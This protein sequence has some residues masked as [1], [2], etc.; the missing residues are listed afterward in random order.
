MSKIRSLLL[1]LKNKS[2]D[3]VLEGENLDILFDSE[4]IDLVSFNL[5]KENKQEI[6]DFLKDRNKDVNLNFSIPK[7]NLR[8]NYPLS[9]SQKNLWI[10]SQ[11]DDANGAYNISNFYEFDG[12]L[13][14]V[15]IES[16]FRFLIERH[17]SLRTVFKEDEN[18]IVRQYILEY[19]D[20]NFKLKFDDIRRVGDAYIKVAVLEEEKKV[21]H[22]ADGPLI[23]VRLLQIDD[24]KFVI[25][26]VMHHIISDGWS[27]E[28]MIKELF[29]HYESSLKNELHT[30][31]SLDI[32]YKDYAVWQQKELKGEKVKPHKE[33]WKKQF[34]GE[35][36][37]L[38]LPAQFKR[39]ALKTYNGK[40][41]RRGI[42]ENNVTKLKE[43][44]QSNGS[45]LFM[46]L[47]SAVEVL[48]YKYTKQENIVIGTATAGRLHPDLEVQI[49]LFVNTL[50]LRVNFKKENSFLE[51][52]RIVKEVTIGAYE[53]QIFPLDELVL[54]LSLKRDISRNALFDVMVDLSTAF[55]TNKENGDTDL[56]D[57]FT[58]RPYADVEN[59]KSRFDMYF[60]F[61]ETPRGLFLDFT[62]NTDI[63]SHNFA[64]GLLDHFE[65][66]LEKI[67]T[68]PDLQISELD[69][70]NKSEKQ[71]LLFEFNN[72]KVQYSED[73]TVVDL[74]E[75]LVKESPDKTAVIF[76]QLELT[77]QNLNEK[78]NQ[79]A[80]YLREKYLIQP[81]DLIGIK[82][83]RS[84]QVL[85]AILGILKAGGGYVPIDPGYPQSRI[86]YIIKDSQCKVVLDEEEMFSF[87]IERFRYKKEN[88]GAIKS[89]SLAYV[90]YTSGTTGNPKGVMVEHRSLLNSSLSR[91]DFYK[92]QRTLLVSSFAFDSSVA[93]IWGGL[94][95]GGTLVIENEEVIKNAEKV[96]KS[97]IANKVTHIL[98]VPSYYTFLFDE[99][100]KH[101]ES[102]NLK[103]LI[104]AGEEVHEDVIAFHNEY[105]DNIELYNEYGPT[106]CTVWSTISIIK[107]S[108]NKTSIGS[109]IPNVQIYIL[110]EE[111]N[112]VPVGIIGKIFIS[113]ANVAR[114]Y[115]NKPE[116]TGEKFIVNPFVEGERMYDSGDL[117]C[118]MPDG[119][120]VFL[121]R[122]DNQVKIR[123]HRIELGEIEN[124]ILQ[125]SDS[126]K[127]VIV[128]LKENNG[129][130]VLA[131]Y[132]ESSEQIDKS[133]LRSFLLDKLPYYMIPG[134]YVIMQNIPLTLHGKIDRKALPSITGEDINIKEYCPA[135]NLIEEDL[136]AI[137]KEVLGVEKLGI[138]DNFFELGGHSL[139]VAQAINRI[140]K[141]INK[142]ISFKDFFAN[143]TISGL[144]L[145]LE[146]NKYTEIPIAAT[147]A[148]YPLT[149][150]QSRLWVLSQLE[151]GSLAYNMPAAIKLTGAVDT[152]RLKEAFKLL[153]NRHEILRTY[154]KVS[155]DGEVLQYIIP[156]EKVIFN[157]VEK[158][159]NLVENNEEIIASYLKAENE[160]L[161]DLEQGPLLR[162]SLIKLKK[163]EFLFF[164]SM[165]H[166]I[167]DG[168]SIE[169]LVSEIIK[170]YN[171]LAQGKQVDLKEFRIQYKDYAVWL[172][173]ES[174]QQKYRASEDYWLQQFKGELPVLSLPTFKTRPLIKTYNGENATHQ[175]S[176]VFLQKLQLFSREQ[177]VTL[178]M[179]LMAG[180]NALLCRYTGQED[181]IIGTPIAGREHPDLENQ[182]GLYL[183]T[184]A[185]RTQFDAKSN[186]LDLLAKQK[187]TLLNAYEHQ[188][189]PFDALVGK[190]NFKRDVSRSALFDALVVLQSQGQLKNQSVE[191]LN[192]IEVV[193]FNFSGKT[194]QFDISFTFIETESLTLVIE[195]NTDI[196]DDY[197]I[198]RIF[199]HFENLLTKLI[200]EP[201]ILIAEAGYLTDSE[202]QQLLTEF[203]N[204]DVVYASDKTIVDLFEEQVAKTPDDLAIV[205]EDVELTYKE[206]NEKANQLANYLTDRYSIE[207]DDLIGIKLDISEKMIIAVLGILKSGAAYVPID[208]NY[209][210]E[211]ILYM[212]RDSKCK[213]I[214]D[215]EQMMLFESEMLKYN[216]EN[217]NTLIKGDSLAYVIYTS[218]TTGNPKGVMVENQNLYNSSICRGNYYKNERVL[219][220]SSIAFDSSVGV[221][222]GAFLCG[223]TLIIIGDDVVKNPI[224]IADKIL[225]LG[226]TDMVCVPS[227]Y[228][229]LSKEL[230][231]HKK[232]LK[233]KS[234]LLAGEQLNTD[235]LLFHNK[236]F[237]AVT[238]YNE[239]GPTEATVWATVSKINADDKIIV[240]GKP[241]SN[242]QMYILDD[243]LQPVAV[244]G[245]GKIYIS[246]AGLARGY[247]N[248]PELTAEKFVSNPF[249]SNKRMY[250]TGD[251]GRWLPD[252]SIEFLGRKDDQVKLRGYRI[253]LSEIE[254]IISQYS[255]FIKHT[256]AEIQEV[257]GE[258]IIVG[259]YVSTSAIN[260][261]DLR[262]Y[263]KTK[264]PAFMIPSFFIELNSIPVTPNGKVDKNALPSISGADIIRKEYTAPRSEIEK[265][266]T[267]IWQEVLGV[268]N[269]GTTDDFFE[270]GGHSIKIIKIISKIKKQLK[271]DIPVSLFFNYPT[272][273][274]FVK[275]LDKRADVKE[276][277]E[278]RDN[279][280]INFLE[281]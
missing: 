255:E 243:Y 184:L 210:Q 41:F 262:S 51:L 32:Q 105:F 128:E 202:K 126:L 233:F 15:L 138:N 279:K 222:W 31:K 89:S 19:E 55:I 75:K 52:L 248:L 230:V 169:L 269:I 142:S 146:E 176:K 181:I 58:L 33:Y 275:M 245:L 249:Q 104:L 72:T 96:S 265:K 3:V 170:T 117:G 168:W 251:Y 2:I 182:L 162:A 150:S 198:Q 204:T 80:A 29:A 256:V 25:S 206:F 276:N 37:I 73:K 91:V 158:D 267:A 242:T 46:G 194:S 36:P 214:L 121:G 67:L 20:I 70:L 156:K 40:T 57:V 9:S 17:E 257:N 115:L 92:E 217:L 174:Q 228:T 163:A 42:N 277:E 157:L 203:N 177:D 254:N 223:G 175:F 235:L 53:H 7:T 131:A 59:L 143:P 247:L 8:V 14:K 101:K 161:F 135:R 219:L 47:L 237:S 68:V 273:E 199:V 124:T 207:P 239:Y 148:S 274:D 191:T 122:Q 102:L 171:I 244:G 261:S 188:S 100:K 1:E 18:G 263:L 110:D 74:F 133:D 35:V 166:I 165:H 253:E 6:I 76:D 54:E 155:E 205:F 151:G 185:I 78:A 114:G 227:Y 5:I 4:E 266:L 178:F 186:F 83:E 220:T 103:V 236:Y 167:G 84:E 49:G 116:L 200:D 81:D 10:S 193:N 94:L 218:G 141:K 212:E 190:L 39:P 28:I 23:S 259:Y 140:H 268:E 93:V 43:L 252:G 139:I 208:V 95:S 62:Y 99:L 224:E 127:Q 180:I 234:I 112:L 250:D 82:L 60:N 270:M 173:E 65:Q 134:Y 179:T 280:V 69:Y 113:G 144:S 34:A 225:Q 229:V 106:E 11:F 108:D 50:P 109:P 120:I 147:A 88:L 136:V 197:L 216:S 160:I 238:V 149:A 98:C 132:L 24:F 209:P 77:Y 187:D 213:F 123:G 56:D 64:A 87:N 271:L 27:M 240:I 119:N 86:D 145:Y 246:G 241:I 153:I 221:M 260:K 48:L 125:Y 232:A 226:I 231:K 281:I 278:K 38:A 45:T 63:Y 44:C 16:S 30:F 201:E 22:L 152:G 172:N 12:V 111:L 85:V 61:S 107:R 154:F 71:Q 164:F 118:W 79:L 258:K 26:L 13:D 192:D 264:L 195:Y 97:I 159:F 189:Y 183:N 66:I 90:I 272:I 137:W 211:R 21:F 215:K 129:D 196:F 130:K